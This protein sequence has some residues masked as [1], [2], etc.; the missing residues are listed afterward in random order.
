MR[1]LALKSGVVKGTLRAVCGYDAAAHGTEN[2]KAKSE[3]ES[4][5]QLNLTVG[6]DLGCTNFRKVSVVNTAIRVG[7]FRRVEEVEGVA[8]QFQR[9]LVGQMDVLLHAEVDFTESGSMDLIAAQGSQTSEYRAAAAVHPLGF[10]RISKGG[11][12]EPVRSSESARALG[13]GDRANY[14]GA[15]FW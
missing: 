14:V 5:C 13:V 3:G 9:V 4:S 2:A 8:V 10:R 15:I 11:T 6:I 1:V 7:E 12:I